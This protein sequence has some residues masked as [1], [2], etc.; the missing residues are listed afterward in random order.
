M[1]KRD[2]VKFGF[3]MTFGRIS[4]IAQIP[5]S[6]DIRGVLAARL[7]FLIVSRKHKG[8]FTSPITSPKWSGVGNGHFPVNGNDPLIICSQYHGCCWF[9][10]NEPWQQQPWYWPSSHGIFWSTLIRQ[11]TCAS[12]EMPIRSRCTQGFYS[13]SEQTFDRKNSWSLESARF[14]FKR[15]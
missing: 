7:T 12:W 4:Y 6:V 13:L 3:K 10:D 15:C 14:G 11:K 9:R 5:R 1:G 8:I 2:F